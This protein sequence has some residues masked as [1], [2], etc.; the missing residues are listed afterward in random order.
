MR[1]EKLH[2]QDLVPTG[3]MEGKRSRGKQR[4]KILDRLIK[5]APSRTSDKL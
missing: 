4:E 5:V 2:E 1:R 3:M